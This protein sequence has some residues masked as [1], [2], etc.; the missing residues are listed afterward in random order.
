MSEDARH[1]E[2]DVRAANADFYRALTG[3]DLAAMGAVWAADP[4]AVCVHPG[5]EALHGWSEIR[6]SWERIFASTKWM[7]VEPTDVRVVAAGDLAV[8]S[9]AENITAQAEEGVGVASARA[10]NVFRRVEGR[11]RM[12]VHHASPV[13]VDLAPPAAGAPQ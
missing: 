13:P 11:W 2:P 8:V 1:A 7:H 4:G 3:L 9:C 12:L 6:E 5:R 10:T